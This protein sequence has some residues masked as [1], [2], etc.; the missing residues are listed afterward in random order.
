MRCRRDVVESLH[1][2]ANG[3]G[4]DCFIR[5]HEQIPEEELLERVGV[6]F[7]RESAAIV[8]LRQRAAALE[9]AFVEAALAF[10]RFGKRCFA[11][12]QPPP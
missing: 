1:L 9:Y 2:F 10:D 11:R 12:F 7:V 3:V 5:R 6:F 8:A 4:I